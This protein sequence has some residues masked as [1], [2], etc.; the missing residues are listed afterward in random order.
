MKE[1]EREMKEARHK[2][3]EVNSQRKQIH[4]K[5]FSAVDIIIT[6]LISSAV[7]GAYVCCMFM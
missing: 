5:K 7:N 4:C 6:L 2:E 3:K 1:L